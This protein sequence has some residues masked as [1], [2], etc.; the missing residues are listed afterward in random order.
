MWPCGVTN[1]RIAL[2]EALQIKPE[3]LRMTF[4]GLLKSLKGLQMALR[5]LRFSQVLR[6]SLGDSAFT[7]RK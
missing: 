5:R 6:I 2:L 4:E 3:G 7:G 1:V